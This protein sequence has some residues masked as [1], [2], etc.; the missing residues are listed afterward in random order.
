[1]WVSCLEDASIDV[2]RV[3]VCLDALV[4][5]FFR[6]VPDL[7]EAW[8]WSEVLRYRRWSRVL[9]TIVSE[10]QW[11]TQWSREHVDR[12][13]TASICIAGDATGWISTC[14]RDDAHIWQIC[15]RS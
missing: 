1:M 3:L 14:G 2:V 15:P 11:R 7:A 6:L 12:Y 10:T 4:V 5:L 8:L 13:V 9:N